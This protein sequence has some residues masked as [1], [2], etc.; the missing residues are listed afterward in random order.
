[1]A[2]LVFLFH[3]FFI[4]CVHL[5]ILPLTQ[6]VSQGD[7]SLHYI[8]STTPIGTAD[9]SWIFP[10]GTEADSDP[11]IIPYTLARINQFRGCLF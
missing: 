8:C 3:G 5:R 2:V 11:S 6:F 7:N 4:H 9:N 1:M 10:N